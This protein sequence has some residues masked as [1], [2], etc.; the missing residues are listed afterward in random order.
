[1]SDTVKVNVDTDSINKLLDD[2][3]MS[4]KEARQSIRY[5]LR[6][7]VTPIQKTAR[8]NLG[9]AINAKSIKKLV[10]IRISRR[11]DMAIV[12]ITKKVERPGNKKPQA[13]L[14]FFERG[15]KKKRY[16]QFRDGQ[17][18]KTPAYRGSI[19]ATSFFSRAVEAH[20]GEAEKTL[21]QIIIDHIKKV[22]NRRK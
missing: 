11:S 12:D 4:N 21:E 18:L 22:V 17:K 20:K 15:T 7:S 19:A 3:K 14:I 10:R 16:A 2:L 9:A 13:L 6:K 5:G 1:M 8:R